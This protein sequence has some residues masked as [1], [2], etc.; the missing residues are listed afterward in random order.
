[1]VHDVFSAARQAD[2]RTGEED[3]NVD[4]YLNS[5]DLADEVKVTRQV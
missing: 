2:T 4:D 5:Q 1:M 3:L